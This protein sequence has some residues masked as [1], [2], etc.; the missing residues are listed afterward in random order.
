M[1]AYKNWGETVVKEIEYEPWSIHPSIID[2]SKIVL[3]ANAIC[4]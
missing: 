3:A 1:D 4:R 2:A